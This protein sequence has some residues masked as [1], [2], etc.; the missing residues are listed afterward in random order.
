MINILI[1]K[2]DN[3]Y[4]QGLGI[5]LSQI[6]KPLSSQG[7][8][9]GNN[10]D[11][12]SIS[13]A[14]IVIKNFSAGETSICHQEFRYRKQN[15]LV[16]GIYEG[17]INPH[18]AEL[19]LCYNNIIFVNRAESVNKVRKVIQR[20]WEDIHVENA[21]STCRSCLDCKHRTLSYQQKRIANL[22]FAGLTTEEIGQ[23]LNI[24]PKTVG[25]HKRMI[26]MKFNLHSDCEL[27]NFLTRLVEHPLP[28]D[29]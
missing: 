11:P 19:P 10:L 14:D 22:F 4:R 20:G 29:S 9:F 12:E 26:M 7:V 16:I 15:S 1:E 24:H 17:N 8:L 23:E 3:F 6:F 21:A 28:P 5:L 2:G 18:Y 27:L 13:H 25:A